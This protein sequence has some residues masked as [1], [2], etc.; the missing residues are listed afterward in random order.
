MLGDGVIQGTSQTVPV[1]VLTGAIPAII[2]CTSLVL[3]ILAWFLWKEFGWQIY[4]T[5]GADRNLKRAHLQYQIYVCLL[6]ESPSRTGS[7]HSLP[8]ADD[9][10]RQS[11]T[12]LLL[13][14]FAFSSSWSC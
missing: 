13:P 6:S 14:P 12:S 2:G 8:F 3:S 11:L 10:C 5:I 1:Q 9:Y 7:S 4:K